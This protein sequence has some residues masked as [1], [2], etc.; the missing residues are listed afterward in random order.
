MNTLMLVLDLGGTFV[1]ALSGAAAG[2]RSRL[3]IFGV[4]V[5]SFVAGNFGGIS[6]DRADRRG[7]AGS[8][9]RSGATC[10]SRCSPG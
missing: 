5:L 8:A 9:R 2:V 7:A 6:R 3:D 1:F 4:L 10:W